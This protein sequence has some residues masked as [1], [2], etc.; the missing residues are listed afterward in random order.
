MRI[1]TGLS[2]PFDMISR[3][4]FLPAFPVSPAGISYAIAS[5]KWAS[6]KQ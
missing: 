2:P 6:N 1:L 4:V 3:S 5:K